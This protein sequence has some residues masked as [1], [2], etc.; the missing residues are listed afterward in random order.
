MAGNYAIALCSQC[1]KEMEHE[2]RRNGLQVQYRP[3]SGPKGDLI[4]HLSFI[5]QI[6]K[7]VEGFSIMFV[8]IYPRDDWPVSNSR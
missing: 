3:Y 5:A 6:E 2:I 1:A 8:W 7:V 4:D